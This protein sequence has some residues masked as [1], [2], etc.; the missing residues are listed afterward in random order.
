MA[1][2]NIVTLFLISYLFFS[3]SPTVSAARVS[4]AS[5]DK[6][7]L[8]L[9][10]ETLCP[11]CSNFIV[12][13][14]PKLFE[15][16]LI[17]IVDLQLVPYGNGKIGS[18][19]TIACQHGTYECLLNTVEACAINA[20]PDLNKHFTFIYC[21]E[22]LVMEDKYSEWESCFAKTGFES[23]P[24][25]DCYNS[26]YGHQL[27]L[28]LAA[29]TKA[30]QPPHTYVPWVT[31]DGQPLYDDYKYFVSFICK[32]YKGAAVPK[33]C[34]ELPVKTIPK[35]EANQSPQVSYVEETAQ[36][37]RSTKIRSTVTT[38]RRQMK[39]ASSE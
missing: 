9:Y 8:A 25:V 24:I 17:Q 5:S 10:Y 36:P 4:S 38:W 33:A 39:M 16:G 22:R 28:K 26:G 18:N 13:Y 3:S 37:T 29:E 11:Y 2:R 1:S 7:T 30:L 20:W 31:V 35:A 14:L 12:N 19:N 34:R 23:K 15:K 6:V 32:A 27:D 21:V